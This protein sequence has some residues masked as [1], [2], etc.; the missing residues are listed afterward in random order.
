MSNN[1]PVLIVDCYLYSVLQTN[2]SV[3]VWLNTQRFNTVYLIKTDQVDYIG[4][5]NPYPD[6]T[7]YFGMWRLVTIRL[8]YSDG[9]FKI[10]AL[11]LIDWRRTILEILA[12]VWCS[13]FW[14]TPPVTAYPS[15]LIWGSSLKHAISLWPEINARY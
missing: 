7:K 9:S 2:E 14:L 11:S 4:Y 10:C 13:G 6:E 1:R 3:C 15:L 8:Y 12:K 5:I